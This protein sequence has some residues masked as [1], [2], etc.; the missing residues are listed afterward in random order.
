MFYGVSFFY[1]SSGEFKENISI[2]YPPP[3]MH[4]PIPYS[5][6]LAILFAQILVVVTF[7]SSKCFGLVYAD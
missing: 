2:N 6:N 3:A 5:N 1:L 4:F 7:G